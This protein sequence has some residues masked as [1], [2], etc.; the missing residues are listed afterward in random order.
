[1]GAF[2]IG[3]KILDKHE[4]LLAVSSKVYNI[5][6]H[7]RIKGKRNNNIMTRNAFL[8]KV[9]INIY[10]KGNEIVFGEK[11]YIIETDISVYGD[12]NSIIIGNEVA[13]YNASICIEDDAGEVTIGDYTR[14]FGPSHLAEIEGTR[15]SIGNRCLFSSDTVLRTGDSHSV[16]DL[17]GNRIN[18]SKD[19]LI[20]D[21]VWVGNKVIITKGVSIAKDSIVATGAVVT[22]KINEKNVVIGG[23]PARVVKKDVSWDIN[24]I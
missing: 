15:I 5:I 21:H 2:S 20:A 22:K 10:G 7:N 13:M 24:R 16:T 4:G 11:C 12:G 8:R 6:G 18:Q 17:S 3:K 14:I 9:R 19:I 23:V 1:M